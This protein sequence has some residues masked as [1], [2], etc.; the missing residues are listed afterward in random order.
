MYADSIASSVSYCRAAFALGL[1][2]GN[3]AADHLINAVKS[4][5]SRPSLDVSI[6]IC[7]H[8]CSSDVIQDLINGINF[9]RQQAAGKAADYTAACN[10]LWPEADVFASKAK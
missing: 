3:K 7:D 2:D 1:L 4:S 8:V 9:V 10:A 6:Y 5:A